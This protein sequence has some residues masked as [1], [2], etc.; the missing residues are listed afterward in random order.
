MSD[1]IFAYWM[2]TAI[3]LSLIS[4]AFTKNTVISVILGFM[5]APMLP[6]IIIA[7]LVHYYFE[8]KR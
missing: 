2:V 8:G 5:L 4:L 3:I 6:L 1:I 7:A